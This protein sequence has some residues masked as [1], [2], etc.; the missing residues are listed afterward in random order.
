MAGGVHREH[1]AAPLG[2][3]RIAALAAGLNFAEPIY[4]KPP[5]LSRPNWVVK[6]EMQNRTLGMTIEYDPSSLAR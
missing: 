1:A 4:I 3:D 6:S 2:F 5:S